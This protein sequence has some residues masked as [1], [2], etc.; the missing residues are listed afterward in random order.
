MTFTHQNNDSIN[1]S[2]VG[3]ISTPLIQLEPSPAEGVRG[4]ILPSLYSDN[5]EEFCFD[6]I[7]GGS[8]DEALESFFTDIFSIPSFPRAKTSDG[9]VLEPLPC[10]R[11]VVRGYRSDDDVY[12]ESPVSSCFFHFSYHRR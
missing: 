5:L 11:P 3:P 6:D 7:F 8:S 4:G 9:P 1:T 12:V 2:G 10:E